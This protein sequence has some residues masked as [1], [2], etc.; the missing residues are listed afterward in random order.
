MYSHQ[1]IYETGLEKTWVMPMRTK[2]VEISLQI[3]TVWSAPLLFAAEL[4]GKTLKFHVPVS[5]PLL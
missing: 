4:C 1:D 3:C 2:E 5:C